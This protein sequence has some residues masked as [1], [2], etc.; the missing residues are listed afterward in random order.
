MTSLSNNAYLKN[1][2]LNGDNIIFCTDDDL[3]L[4]SSLGGRARRIS[5]SHGISQ[6]P[7]ISPTG[8]TVAYLSNDEGQSDIYLQDIWGSIPKRLTFFGVTRLSGWKNKNTLIYSTNAH[9][10]SPRV[11][12]LYELDIE[13][14][15]S[16]P[17]NLG[18]ATLLS[19]DGK[20][21]ILGRNIGDPA[22]WKRYRGGTAGTLWIDEKGDDKF[23]KLLPNL[24]TNLA[25][26][27]WIDGRV[28]FISDHEGVGNIY[29]ILPS[30]R[31]MKRHTHCD[32]YYVRSFSYD[33]GRI[34]YQSGAELHLLEL[35]SGNTKILEIEVPSSFNQSTPR[36]EDADSYLQEFTLRGDSKE[37]AFISRGQLFHRSPWRGAPL[38]K[39]LEGLRYK[40]PLFIKGKDEK[41]NLLLSV[42]LNRENEETIKLFSLDIEDID[43]EGKTLAAKQEFGKTYELKKNP[44]DPLVAMSNNRNELFLLNTLSGK[45]ETIEKNKFNFFQNFNW[46]P[47]GRYLAYA[48]AVTKVKTTLHLYDTKTKKSKQLI[49]SVMADQCPVFSPN[50]DYLYFLGIRS[51]NPIYSETHFDLSFPFAT[52]VFALGLQKNLPSPLELHLDFEDQ[53]DEEENEEEPKAKKTAKKKKAKTTKGKVTKRKVIEQKEADNDDT[54]IDWEGL[55]NRITTLPVPMGGYWQI[56]AVSDKLFML[57]HNVSGSDGDPQQSRMPS[58]GTSVYS[59][60]F[61]DKKY[62]TFHK[63]CG[64]FEVSE[65]GSHIILDTEDGLRLC[66]TDS[67]PTEGSEENKKDGYISLDNIQLHVTPKKEWNQMY[68]EG[69]ILQRENFWASDMS[70]VN[71][72]KVYNDYLPLLD[73]V[74]T[75]FEFSDLMW[76]M[77]GELGTSHC[78][79]FG[80]DYFR[81]PFPYRHGDL[82]AELTWNSKENSFSIREMANGDSWV[83][84]AR[85]PLSAPGVSLEKGDKIFG[86]EGRP[87]QGQEDLSSA[88]KARKG[89]KLSLIVQRKGNSKKELVEITPVGSG[90]LARYRDWVEGN[91]ELVH[92]LSK[93]T[94]GYVHIPDMGVAGFSEFYRN[95]LTEHV[96]EGLIV[97]VRYNG[98]GHVSQHILKILAQ[99]PIG[100]DKARHMDIESYPFYAVN[101]PIVALTN[102]HAGS[103]GDIFSHSF[104][105]MGIGTLLG[106]RTWGGVV[107]IWPRFT[108]NDGS[109]TSQP[110]F[111]FWFKDVGYNVEN[112]GT[113]PD[114]EV[115]RLPHEWKQGKDAQLEKSVQEVL[116]Q[117]KK[118]PPLKPNLNKDR[119]NLRPPRLPKS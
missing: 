44:C 21:R 28:F 24:K 104:K 23:K 98:G 25:N 52:Q 46:S 10:F 42:E 41:E 22:R 71:W 11:T 33:N 9:T 14:L 82:A 27:Q 101:G 49:D 119:P 29:S 116:K 103:D 39:G 67:K 113:D 20:K 5:N 2:S 87:F 43:V 117:R 65:D 32:P 77:Q 53:D 83:S 62:D 91:K 108:L 57:K 105:L 115:D 55:E 112:Y 106:M 16:K 58:P 54:Q 30:G 80:G 26:P 78:Y 118:N 92:K 13:T 3:W 8:N 31:G 66:S 15:K 96:K 56:A 86:C 38:R 84:Q 79:E 93:G 97:D 1:P 109:L 72:Q 99:K 110:E 107:G 19:Y 7:F 34:C 69:W 17:L 88:L 50:G 63:A 64:S 48:K 74:H 76:E 111:S 59:F 4:V 100:F 45:V 114:I 70:K 61:K 94:V 40:H 18:H 6:N 85:S 36:L 68:E 73:K 95:Y 51:F 37:L 89:E 81:K 60:C 75:R 47:C 90:H 12:F 35:K 102:E